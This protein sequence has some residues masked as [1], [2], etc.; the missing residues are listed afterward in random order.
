MSSL[1]V[2]NSSFFFN[3]ISFDQRNVDQI[4]LNGLDAKRLESPGS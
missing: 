2:Q 1:L 4:R 3:F